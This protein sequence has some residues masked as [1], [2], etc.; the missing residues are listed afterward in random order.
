MEHSK[1]PWVLYAGKLIPEYP[2][3]IVEV[4]DENGKAICKWT[5]FDGADQS[6]AIRKAN[7]AFIVEACNNYE[8]LREQNKELVEALREIA[9]DPDYNCGLDGVP[10]QCMACRFSRIATSAI[11]RVGK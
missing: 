1:T 2:N 7:A 9:N 8:R 3:K 6:P 11:E 4:Q 5:G 10:C